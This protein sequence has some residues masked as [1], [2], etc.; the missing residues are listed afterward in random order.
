MGRYTTISRRGR[1]DAG[2]TEILARVASTEGFTSINPHRTADPKLVVTPNGPPAGVGS[3]FAF[4]GKDGTG[5]QTV[6]AVTDSAVAYDIDMGIMGRSQQRIVTVPRPAGG[7]DVEWSMTL[8]A[9][10]NPMLRIFGLM[11]D[12]V[13]G[14]T[15]ETGLRNLASA[16]WR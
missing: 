15:L 8:D 9:G 1:V 16:T 4:R 5:T 10:F 2:A 3:G 12:R 14:A 7:C 6:S 11:A 13:L